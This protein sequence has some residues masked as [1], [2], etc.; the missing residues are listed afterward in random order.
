MIGGRRRRGAV[1]EYVRKPSKSGSPDVELHT[2]ALI[3]A[4][5]PEVVA[6]KPE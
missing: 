5:H 4:V 1:S 3:L 6:A 2:Q